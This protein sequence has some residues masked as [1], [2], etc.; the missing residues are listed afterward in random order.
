MGTTK[1]LRVL[2]FRVA[3]A[4]TREW[5]GEPS[6]STGKHRCRES[7][8]PKLVIICKYPRR[9]GGVESTLWIRR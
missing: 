2:V 9:G 6:H 7:K 5:R 1:S 3:V 4:Q 8:Q